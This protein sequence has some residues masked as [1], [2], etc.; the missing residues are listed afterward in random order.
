MDEVIKNPARS[1]ETPIPEPY[2]PEYKR[3]GKTPIVQEFHSFDHS[4]I[5]E[6]GSEKVMNNS[7]HI[8][9]NNENVMYGVPP[10]KQ[11]LEPSPKTPNVGEYIL[12][13]LGKIILRGNKEEILAEAKSIL[14]GEHPKYSERHIELSDII[15]LKRVELKVGVF[16]ND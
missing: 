6:D 8:I 2:I 5:D 10:F 16:F 14:Y 9:D 4:Y 13:V 15:V 7:G 3:L 1:E 12:M 11:K